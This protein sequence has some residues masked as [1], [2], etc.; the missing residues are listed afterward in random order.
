MMVSVSLWRNF[1]SYAVNYFVNKV[2]I[3][4]E[5]PSSNGEIFLLIFRTYLCY[6]R[7]IPIVSVSLW[8]NFSSYEIGSVSDLT[9]DAFIVSVSLRSNF[10]SYLN[11][12]KK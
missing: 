12:V 11:G 6:Y 2:S 10:P 3:V 4:V 9:A 1:P 5:F 7:R 8:R